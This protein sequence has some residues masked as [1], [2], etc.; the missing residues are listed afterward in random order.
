MAVGQLLDYSRFV[1]PQLRLALLL[2]EL[3]REDLQ[4]FVKSAGVEIVWR[5]GKKFRDS[6]DGE[7][8]GAE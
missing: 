8:A 1:Q 7:R 4:R 6:G 2:P 3:P 5:D